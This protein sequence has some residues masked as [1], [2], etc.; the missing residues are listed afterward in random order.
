[1][2]ASR[3]SQ[4]Y[5]I[6]R[7]LD[8]KALC[9]LNNLYA[10][11]PTSKHNKERANKIRREHPTGSNERTYLN[12]THAPNPKVPARVSGEA[13]ICTPVLQKRILST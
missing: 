9:N 2:L 11:L 8:Y 7:Y 3:R 12:K 5:E 10:L 13:A 4:N 1:M 6:R